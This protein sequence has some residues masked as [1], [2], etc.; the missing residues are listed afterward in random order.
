MWTCPNCGETIPDFKKSCAF[1]DTKKP[2]FE[3]NHCI[4]PNCKSYKI[5]LPD[6]RKVCQ[7]CGELT[8]AGKIIKE[9]S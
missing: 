4:N 5:K 6:Q 7:D 3:E 2:E 1:C 9:L 8:Y